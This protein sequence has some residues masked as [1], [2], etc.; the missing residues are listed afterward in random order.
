M[1]NSVSVK[2]FVGIDAHNKT[3][4]GQVMSHNEIYG[5]VVNA[6]GF[7]NCKQLIPVSREE[8]VLAYKQ[9]DEHFNTISLNKWDA[10]FPF[11]KREAIRAGITS[12]SISEGVCI[13]KQ[14]A[15]MW[16]EEK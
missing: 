13:L 7:E 1:R 14:A 16:A 5:K 10:M 11:V 12:L 3:A 9:G 6:I 8:I 15:R 4:D 2:Q